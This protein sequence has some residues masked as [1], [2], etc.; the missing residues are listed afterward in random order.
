MGKSILSFSIIRPFNEISKYRVLYNTYITTIIISLNELCEVYNFLHVKPQDVTIS[1][2]IITMDKSDPHASQ[3]SITIPEKTLLFSVSTSED[4]NLPQIWESL[5]QF[6]SSGNIKS[7]N[8]LLSCTSISWLTPLIKTL[9]D[10]SYCRNNFTRQSIR[11]GIPYNLRNEVY[12]FIYYK[13]GLA[14]LY[15]YL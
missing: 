13:I 11:M 12:L 2:N 3:I 7:N 15:K 8:I 6:V 14:W 5:L 4:S 10:Q 1:L 9:E